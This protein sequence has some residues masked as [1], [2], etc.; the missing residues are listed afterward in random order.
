MSLLHNAFEC[1]KRVYL[2]VNALY[3]EAAKMEVSE[4]KSAIA[5]LAARVEK[6]REWL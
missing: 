3:F 6:I 1:D 5:A 4:L 2:K